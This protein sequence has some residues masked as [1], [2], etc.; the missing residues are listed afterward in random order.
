MQ[1]TETRLIAISKLVRFLV[2]WHRNES[3][4]INFIIRL[5][6]FINTAIEI[7]IH[8]IPNFVSGKGLIFV[9]RRSQI[10]GLKPGVS[11]YSTDT[12]LALGIRFV[13]LDPYHQVQFLQFKAR[14]KGESVAHFKV[15]L[16]KRVRSGAN[17]VSY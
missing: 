1:E 3:N 8:G 4:P 13:C 7:T 17:S 2:S 5:Q 10:F 14:I 11:R 6:N 12:L 15:F 16:A 9:F